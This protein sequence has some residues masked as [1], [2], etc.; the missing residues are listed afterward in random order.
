MRVDRLDDHAGIDL[1]D[2]ADEGFDD[3]RDGRREGGRAGLDAPTRPDL[4]SERPSA[5]TT[6]ARDSNSEDRAARFAEY[7]EKVDEVYRTYAVDQGCERVREIAEKIVTP[8]MQRIEAEDPS[9]RLVGLEHCLKGKERLSEKVTAAMTERARTPAEAFATVK[10]AIR[11]T[12]QYTE[13]RYSDGVLQDCGR[14]KDAGFE[15]VDRKNTWSAEQYKGIN[16]RWR[17]PDTGQI[18]EVQFHTG[19]SFDAKQVTHAAYERLRS[20]GTSKA[21]Q[22]ELAAFQREVSSKI[23][24]PPGATDIPEYR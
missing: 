7:R 2:D 5:D 8:A 3:D 19:S 16:S 24:V 6:Q 15:P 4:E 12:F 14:L 22:D 21:E 10:D 20:P 23:P 1:D 9:R 11:Y 18:F 13:D 17:V